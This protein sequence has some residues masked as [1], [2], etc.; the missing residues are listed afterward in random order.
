MGL[1]QIDYRF[2]FWA[3]YHGI[4]KESLRFVTFQ[5]VD[6]TPAVSRDVLGMV[7]LQCF[8]GNWELNQSLASLLGKTETELKSQSPVKVKVN[9]SFLNLVMISPIQ[10]QCIFSCTILANPEV[11]PHAPYTYQSTL[12]PGE[13]STSRP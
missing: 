7:S 3:C 4:E 13:G 8:Q 10:I 9:I 6:S 12:V 11:E 1:G 2:L 5:S